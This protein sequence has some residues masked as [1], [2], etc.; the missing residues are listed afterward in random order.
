MRILWLSPWMR[1]LA[2]A[3]IEALH[4]CG[5]ECLLITSDQHYEPAEARGYE[6]VL[7]PHP[8]DPRTTGPLLRA[9]A[10]AR[11][12]RPHIVLVELV[13]DPRWI[14]FTRLAP[15][16][17]LIH[18]DR[19]HDE[20]EHRPRWQQWLTRYFSHRASGIIAFSETVAARIGAE[21]VPLTS[22]V[23]EHEL[24]EPVTGRRDFVLY[25]R[26][27]PYKNIPFVLR[28]WEQHLGSGHRGDR[29]LIIGDGEPD[30]GALPACCEWRR[31]RYSYAEVLPVL[32]AAKGSVAHYR[33]ATQSGVQLLSLQLGV[34][35]IVSDS[36]ALPEFLAPGEHPI[37]VQDQHGLTEAF[38]QLADPG[39]AQR[40]G[41]A[42]REHY[43]G[44]YTAQHAA[45][46]LLAIAERHARIG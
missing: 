5:H 21:T 1:P 27:S 25:G 6:R 36:G 43:L 40:R 24:P 19:P 4:A 32:G 38:D 13:W 23:A 10:E 15:A 35:P 3:Q 7:E 44:H 34:T 14:A 26:L 45:D 20:H 39:E 9:L 2:R 11:R 33:T 41:K 29:L 37:G 28:A 31:G 8:K 18:D 12:F 22:D 42:N 46:R 30:F 17:H 16:L